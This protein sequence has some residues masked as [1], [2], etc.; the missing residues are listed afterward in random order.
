MNKSTEKKEFNL[1][2]APMWDTK[3][4]NAFSIE[5]G[6]EHYDALQQVEVGGKLF[7]KRLPEERRKSENSPNAYLEYVSKEEVAKFKAENPGK[8][9]A[10]KGRPRK[11]EA[12]EDSI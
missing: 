3:N 9:G 11:Q 2:L 5:I 7:L 8:G 12:E 10:K 1:T 6:P 4:G